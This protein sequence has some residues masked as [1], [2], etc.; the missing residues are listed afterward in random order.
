MTPQDAQINTDEEIPTIK[1]PRD[2]LKC[3]KGDLVIL[4][5]RML[6]FIIQ[7]NDSN[8]K[9]NERKYGLTRFH[10]KIAPNISVFNYFTRLTKYSLLEHSVLLSAV[11]YIDLLSNVYP[12]FNLNSLTAHRFLLTATTIASKGLCDSFCT[13]THYSKVGGVQCNELNVLEN[14]FLRKVNYRIIP[15]DN[16]ISFCKM[17]VQKNFFILPELIES[18]LAP[19]LRQGYSSISNA[20]YN[21]LTRYYYKIIEVVGKYS[22]SPDKTKKVNYDIDM[23]AKTLHEHQQNDAVKNCSNNNSN[24]QTASNN[25]PI[26]QTIPQNRPKR[27]FDTVE[28]RHNIYIEEKSKMNTNG[29]AEKLTSSSYKKQITEDKKNQIL[30]NSIYPSSI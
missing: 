1:L 14:E 10:S 24:Y 2:F 6:Q 20:G 23:P 26:P 27:N 22:S 12:A 13:N 5:A 21:V 30:D 3:P 29:L 16:N 8:I 19:S 18:D 25:I 7:I 15:R 4:I 11:Y 17:E 9:E 28:E